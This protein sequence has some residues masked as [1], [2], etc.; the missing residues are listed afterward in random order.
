MSYPSTWTGL[1]T[2]K[3][4]TAAVRAGRCVAALMGSQLDTAT[5]W[6]NVMFRDCGAATDNPEEGWQA[7][8]NEYN[9]QAVRS[10]MVGDVIFTANLKAHLIESCGTRELATGEAR[11]YLLAGSER[12]KIVYPTT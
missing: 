7:G 10:L 12:F 4:A 5:S 9:P 8:Q 1:M 6:D 3:D 2:R 11:T